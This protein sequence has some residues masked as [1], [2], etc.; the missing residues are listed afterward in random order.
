MKK[1]ISLMILPLLLLAACANEKKAEPA[2][3]EKVDTAIYNVKT[4][5][6]EKQKISRNIEYTASLLPYEEVH[7][8]P[9]APGRI[10]EINV[11]VGS[12]VRKGGLIARMDRTQLITA[13]EQLQSAQTNFMRMDTLYKLKSV[14]Q[15]AWEAAKTQYEIAKTNVD[16][17]NRNTTLTAPIGGVITGKYYE[18]GELYSGV[19]NTAAGKAAIVTIQQINPL[20][21]KVNV[22]ERYYPYVKAG[23][24]AQVKVDVY[25]DVVTGR[26]LKVYPTISADSRTFPVE[27]SIPNNGQKFR[28]GMF[29]RVAL[30]MGE[31]EALIAPAV[32]VVK[33]EGTN[34]FFIFTAGEDNRAHKIKVEIGTRFDDKLEVIADEIREG[35]QII[36]AGQ[37]KL[38]D[39]SQIKIVK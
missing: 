4:Q 3:G 6:L 37:N 36:V 21:I 33:Q 1:Y 27:I 39:G 22:S 9:A 10:E 38:M 14:S 23:M 5:L 26:V 12:Y 29:A 11:Q 18:S 17:L 8:A 2:T 28:P 34:N 20:K 24:K 32:A 30:D 35:V 15:Q 13:T 19:P 31:E 7:Y 16:F 25:E